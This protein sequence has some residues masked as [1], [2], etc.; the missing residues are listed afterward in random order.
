MKKI[1]FCFVSILLISCNNDKKIVDSYNR[2]ILK[3]SLLTNSDNVDT[4]FL[5]S[6]DDSLK[7]I[8]SDLNLLKIQQANKDILTNLIDSVSENIHVARVTNCIMG[9]KYSK[10]SN[11]TDKELKESL[12]GGN[13]IFTKMF[14]TGVLT[15]TVIIKNN[16]ECETIHQINDV[17]AQLISDFYG[18]TDKRNKRSNETFKYIGNDEFQ[19]SNG[20]ILKVTDPQNCEVELL[21]DTESITGQNTKDN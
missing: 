16:Y 3:I 5:N 15:E 8:N 6:L 18:G 14:S 4:Y 21:T 11:Y 1:V 9:N 12:G 17:A 7:V 10:T 19:I 20:W 2:R 13:D